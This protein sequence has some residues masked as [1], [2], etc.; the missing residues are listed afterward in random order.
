MKNL[1][2]ISSVFLLLLS[3]AG[4]SPLFSDSL[5]QAR[6]LLNNGRPAEASKLLEGYD[7]KTN[8]DVAQLQGEIFLASKFYREA[9]NAFQASCAA[10]ADVR[11]FT[12]AGAVYMSMGNYSDALKSFEKAKA[13]SPQDSTVYSNCGVALLYLRRADEARLAYEN[14]IRL[15][16]GNLDAKTNLA[17]LEIR[18]N[19]YQTGLALLNEVLAEDTD[20]YFAHLFAGY[21]CY[22]L[23]RNAEAMKH[24]N[25]GLKANPDSFELHYYRASLFY[26]MGNSGDALSDLDEADRLWP[27]NGKTDILRSQIL[28]GLN[29]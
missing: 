27:A 3:G 13:L 29:R 28:K 5:D 15:D 23:K 7:P 6:D 10:Q 26:R 9:L 25:A 18:K 19:Q 21:A 22:R 12:G 17:I 11:C 2:W 16:Q 20:D 14:A 4:F 8:S 1:S 24:Y